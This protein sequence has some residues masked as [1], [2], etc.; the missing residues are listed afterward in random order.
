MQQF[1]IFLNLSGFPCAVVG[2]GEVASRKVS[3]LLKAGAELTVIAP[4]LSPE[5]AEL[6][7]QKQFTYRQS[8]WA[9]ELIKDMRLVVA[10]TDD[11]A[12][13]QQIYHYCETHKI[14][15][16]AV[17]QPDICR[18][19]TPS[20]VNRSPLII[21]ISSAGMSPV[22]A[23]RIR[24]MLETMLPQN[25]SAIAEYAGG[26][27]DKIKKAFNS[28]GERRQFWEKFFTSAIMTRYDSLTEHQKEQ[29]VDDMIT[30]QQAQGEVWLVGAGP[31]DP[32][33][34]TLKAVQKMQ[35][36]DVI[37]HDR[38]VS[39]QILDLARKDAEFICVGKQKNKHLKQQTEINQL[40]V[41][42]AASGKKVCRL[43]GGDPFIFGRGGEELETLVEQQIPFEVVPAVTAAAGC[44]SYA[45]I[46]LTHRDYARKVVFVTGQNSKA[47][48][49][50]DWQALVRPYQTL[51]IY[52][53]LARAAL[54]EDELIKHGMSPDTPVAII[55]NGTTAEQKVFCCKLNQLA[56]FEQ[57]KK[58]SPTLLIIGEVVKLHPKLNWYQSSHN[59]TTN[60]FVNYLQ[61]ER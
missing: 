8:P 3:A 11:N 26:L 13:N 33:L 39:S 9:A 38:L 56:D 55:E 6:A 61:N 21:A 5:L 44:A 60:A 12:I 23:R 48:E 40:L 51:V 19:T 22:L 45:G 27:R 43:K 18:Y 53:G 10:A 41:E 54:I 37:V 30:G 15:V 49:Q 1:P 36:A 14:L 2:G 59:Q 52:M 4:K 16:N 29:L 17:D 47:G 25:L 20:I 34:L 28:I 7:D 32:E 57:H 31:G 50:P 24:A 58:G 46:P 42:Q 35:M